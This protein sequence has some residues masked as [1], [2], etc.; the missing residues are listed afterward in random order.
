MY[1]SNGFLSMY[2]I[3]GHDLW[4]PIINTKVL[5]LSLDVC[6]FYLPNLYKQN[7]VTW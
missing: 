7:I 2:G 4:T 1:G 3:D 6:P 5:F